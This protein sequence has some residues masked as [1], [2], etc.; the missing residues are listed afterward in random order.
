MPVSSSCSSR[1]PSAR[2]R[3]LIAGIGCACLLL[4]TLVIVGWHLHLLTLVQLN[5]GLAPMNYNTA[6]CFVFAG[7][8]LGAWAYGGVTRLPPILGALI[9]TIALLTVA[10][11]VFRIDLGIDQTLFHDYVVTDTSQPGRM[12]PVSA[13]CFFL[14]GL[15]FLILSLPGA[16]RWRGAAAGSAASVIIS[17]SFVGVL[18][19]GIGLPG[20]SGWGELTPVA[21]HTAV[22]LGLLG[23]AILLIAWHLTVLP[24]EKTPRW[25]P[26]PLSISILTGS[27][28]LYFALAAKQHEQASQTVKFGAESASNQITS[29]IQSRIRGFVHTAQ[30]WGLYGQPTENTWERDTSYFLRHSPDIAA[31]AWIDPTSQARWIVPRSLASAFTLDS[32]RQAALD[33]AAREHQPIISRIVGLSGSSFGFIVYVPIVAKGQ[34]DG[35]IAAVFDA[36]ASLRRFLPPSVADGQSIAIFDGRQL[37]FTRDA[38]SADNRQ[39]M[40]QQNIELPGVTWNLHIWPGLDLASRLDS[41]LPAVVLCSGLIC[42][43][44]LGGVCFFAQ[45]SSHQAAETRRSNTAL[46]A[47]LDTVKTLQG[48]LPICASCKRV[49]D[50]SGYWSQIDTY[51]GQHTNASL[52]H[53]YCPECAAKAFQEFG[54]DVPAEVQAAVAAG[55][56]ESPQTSHFAA[57]KSAPGTVS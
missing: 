38:T 53:G 51:L 44:L 52:S 9:A 6:V 57:A 56:F 26:A 17:L 50:D 37:F 23:I 36:R 35:F 11:Y 24:G 1:E 48:L 14:T 32:R 34:P 39:D 42:S 43:L 47:A 19:Y 31:L 20:P 5:P 46:Q 15:S 10:E 40:V 7:L 21:V 3:L 16:A 29:R 54:F 45:R 12:S 30:L 25:L 27:L 8:A 55:N 18:G 22:G 4:G 28:V 49:R 41:P 2:L 33:Q 13:L